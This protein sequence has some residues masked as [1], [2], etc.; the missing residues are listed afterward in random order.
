MADAVI[1]EIDGRMV[2]VG[3][4]W[5][6]D[7]ASS[8]Y[9]GLDADPEVIEAIP[10]YLRSWGTQPG[11]S[12]FR[13]S[14]VLYE[15]LESALSGLVGTE[16]ALVFPT[17]TDIHLSVFPVLADSGSVFVDAR[18]HKTIHDGCEVARGH[19]ATVQ[20]FR[21]SDPRDLER[22][23]ATSRSSPRVVCIEGVNGMTGN[24]PDVRAFA[25][26]ARRYD[27]LLYIDDS[28]GF[29]ILGER[30]PD[31][32]CPYG[33]GGNG[34]VR[35][36]GE[37]YDNIVVVAGL[38]KAFSSLVAFVACPRWLKEVLKTAAPPYLYSE[39][40][41]IAS[42]ATALEGLKV[43]AGR[44]DLL[45]LAVHRK[46]RRVLDAL[47]SLGV[48]TPNASGHPIV[49]LPLARPEDVDE[50]GLHLF[51]RGIYATIAPCPVVP[52]DEVGFRVQLTAATSD[53]HIEHLIEVL[54]EVSGRLRTLDRNRRLRLLKHG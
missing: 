10:T 18:A 22:L 42:M 43:N 5:L 48:F 53:E 16:D 38:S 11:W 26:M 8:S 36:A 32:L 14:P 41:P 2:R 49:E 46:T 7:F 33:K 21:H 44:G 15:Q 20:R 25:T 27:A 3:D 12:R 30:A 47:D 31:E 51:H 29:G 40:S 19:G 50:V 9:L 23:L 39:P 17:R 52:P 6:A 13:G 35:H 45:R 4:R 34:V 1:E 28:H 24:A 54:G 37:E